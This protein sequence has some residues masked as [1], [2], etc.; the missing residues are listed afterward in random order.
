M[1]VV[2]VTMRSEHEDVMLTLDGQVGVALLYRDIVRVT[3]AKHQIQLIQPSGRNYFEVL[4][5][6]LRW[7]ER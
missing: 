1:A 6:K 7:G 5:T 2:E 3:K 4:K